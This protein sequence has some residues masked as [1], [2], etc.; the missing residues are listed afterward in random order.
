MT[1]ILYLAAN[2][3][4][5]YSLYIFIDSFL[6]KCKITTKTKFIVY[7]FYY[8]LGVLCWLFSR[9]MTLNLFVNIVP[10]FLITL[11]YVSSLKKKVFSTFSSCAVGMFIDWVTVSIF[12]EGYLISSGFVQCITLLILTSLF[13]HYY[14]NRNL[15]QFKSKYSWLL[16]II[17][18]GIILV[19]VLTIN[20][21]NMH[22]VIIAVVL[23]LINFLNFYIYNIEQKN[24]LTQHKLQLIEFSNDAYQHQIQ[25]MSESQQKMRYMRHDMRN[26]LNRIRRL[27]EQEAIND[28]PKYL[29]EM[30]DAVTVK[31]EYS[32]TGNMD[33][34]SLLNYE[35]TLASEFGTEI[36]CNI[37]LPNHL[38]I[39]SFDMTVILGNL[40]DNAVEAL[41]HA[42][43][44]VMIISIKLKKG[45]IKID[46]E[47]TYNPSYVRK[48]DGREH[49]I[50]L[51][52]VT[53][54]I[55]KYH[56]N[57]K[58]FPEDNRYHTTVILFDSLE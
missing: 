5:I 12:T 23:L 58:T 45:I 9:N 26:H 46:I 56:G 15:K 16:T 14:I 41:Q 31:H 25:I 43:K 7:F 1:D 39:S 35:L 13:N 48:P 49:G 21:S 40:L 50:G 3:L 19:G 51:L 55:K 42:E 37:D 54:T 57:L 20:D 8:V 47:N 36:I 2:A 29:N 11:L 10:L 27:V 18:I 32:K 33:V 44:R 4:H 30:E 52:S 53:N 22:D 6:G 34:D 28:I 38:N 24:W 17:S